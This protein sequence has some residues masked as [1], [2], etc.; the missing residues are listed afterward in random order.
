MV[1]KKLVGLLAVSSLLLAACGSGD[2][3]ETETD[4]TEEASSGS[5]NSGESALEIIDSIESDDLNYT[6]T[7]ELELSGATWTEDGYVYNPVSGEAVIT[8][9]A[10]AT[11]EGVTPYAYIIQDGQVVAKPEV[12]EGKFTYPVSTPIE[13]TTYQVGVSDEDLGAV[14]DEANAEDLIRHETVIVSATEAEPAAE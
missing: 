11:E 14:G 3:S 5:E 9:T 1:Y 4:T 10:V 8:G 2:E 13:D 6:S 7:I 12:T